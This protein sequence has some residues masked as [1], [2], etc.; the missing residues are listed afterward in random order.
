MRLTDVAIPTGVV[1]AGMTVAEVFR[2]CVTR[3]VPG[4]PF[5]DPSGRVVG[6]ASVRHTLKLTCIPEHVVRGAHMLGDAIDGV[7]IPEAQIRAVLNQ[8]ID[9]FVLAEFVTV[10]P[11]SPVVKALSVMEHFNSGYVF[12]LDGERYAGI[13]TRLGI[14]RLMLTAGGS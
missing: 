1:R 12:L 14:V 4:L 10:S 2:E 7:A 9:P 11:A 8:A 5:C 13:V 3:N 6:R